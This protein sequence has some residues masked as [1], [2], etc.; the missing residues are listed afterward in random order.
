VKGIFTWCLG[1][2]LWLCAA[3]AGAEL[4]AAWQVDPATPTVGDRISATLVLTHPVNEPPLWDEFSPVFDGAEA[5]ASVRDA[6]EA[7]TGGDQV[8]RRT[9]T[10]YADLPGPVTL[11]GLAVPLS[12]GGSIVVTPLTVTVS[13]AFDPAQPPPL[14]PAKAPLSVP[15]S[16]GIYALA[17]GLLLAI[18]G[19]LIWWWRR[20][21]APPVVAPPP[22]PPRPARE[23]ALERLDA[24]VQSDLPS[25]VFF[26]ELS[27]ITR[28]F[29]DGSCGI[30]AQAMSRDEVMAAIAASDRVDELAPVSVWLDGWELF[31][32]AKVAPDE[33]R[34][35]VDFDAVRAW[36][37]AAATAPKM[38]VVPEGEVR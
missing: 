10:L 35:R 38:T 19:G 11:P 29:L 23:V 26:G 7:V 15:L 21:P 31:Q 18:L 28:E 32:F 36:V 9:Y 17:A 6:S 22:V 1:G 24:L 5:D 37:V 3:S 2:L 13:G 33:Q 16:W 4:S 27:A 20:R 34:Q 14:A 30:P 25:R 8:S 12:G